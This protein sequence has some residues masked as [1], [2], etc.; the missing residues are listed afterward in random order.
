[1]RPYEA[2]QLITET[3]VRQNQRWDS[4]GNIDNSYPYPDKFIFSELEGQLAEEVREAFANGDSTE[5]DSILFEPVRLKEKVSYGGYS[6]YTQEHFRELTLTCGDHTIVFDGD[7]AFNEL[8]EWTE[9]REVVTATFNMSSKDVK[10]AIEYAKN[11]GW[12]P[13]E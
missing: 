8:L 11:H 9:K 4:E 3:D 5:Y 2:Y 12:E 7:N 6:E 13:D 10:S 1:M